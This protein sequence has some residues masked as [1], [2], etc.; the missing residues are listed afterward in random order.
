MSSGLIEERQ[1]NTVNIA[2]YSLAFIATSYIIW[3]IVKNIYGWNRNPKLK[4]PEVKKYY[5]YTLEKK[6]VFLTDKVLEIGDI[7][8]NGETV[9]YTLPSGYKTI[10]GD[11]Y[12]KPWDTDKHYF[13]GSELIV[14]VKDKDK[15]LYGINKI[16]HRYL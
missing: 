14:C 11:V 15:I 16:H 4:I 1:M 10:N 12:L 9:V 5:V 3:R 6:E 7:A 2:I 13:I 8:S